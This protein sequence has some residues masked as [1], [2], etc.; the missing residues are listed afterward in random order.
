MN[1][2]DIFSILGRITGYSRPSESTF[3]CLI[4]LSDQSIVIYPVSSLFYNRGTKIS[5]HER[6]LLRFYTLYAIPTVILPLIVLK[7]KIRWR[8]IEASIEAY[9]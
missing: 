7:A 3:H 5:T 9:I 4:P 8:Y 6:F 2:F 1:K